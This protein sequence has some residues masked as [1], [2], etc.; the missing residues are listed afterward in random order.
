MVI[1]IS[2]FKWFHPHDFHLTFDLVQGQIWTPKISFVVISEIDSITFMFGIHDPYGETT[3]WYYGLWTFWCNYGLEL[4]LR[5]GQ[6]CEISTRV[7]S[8]ETFTTEHFTCAWMCGRFGE[9]LQL[10]AMTFKLIFW[11]GSR[12]NLKSKTLLS[13]VIFSKVLIVQHSY[14]AYMILLKNHSNWMVKWC[15][16]G[17]LTLTITFEPKR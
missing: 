3:Q 6:L 2:P 14:L 5:Q 8:S 9:S 11:H 16:L 1:E 17:I 15:D 7:I 10:N 13:I 4:C 12:S